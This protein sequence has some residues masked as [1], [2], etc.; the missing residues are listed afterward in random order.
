MYQ[1][2]ADFLVIW[3]ASG[4]LFFNA[5]SEADC[6]FTRPFAL[7][8]GSRIVGKRCFFFTVCKR[9]RVAVDL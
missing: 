6:A 2:R 9:A 5:F 1:D 4:Q 3:Y 8:R 7:P